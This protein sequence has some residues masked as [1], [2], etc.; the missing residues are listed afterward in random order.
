[1]KTI[2]FTGGGTGGHIYPGIAVAQELQNLI[3][4]RIL[5]IGNQ[6]GMDRSIVEA[7]GIEFYGIPS[8]KFRRYLSYKNLTDIGKVLNGFFKARSLLAQLKPTFLFS[9]GGFVS[10]P[11]CAAAASLGIPVFSHESDYTPG[12]A[13]KINSRFSSKLFTAYDDTIRF[14]P[15][16]VQSRSTAVGNPVRRSFREADADAGRRFLGIT[17]HDPV[18]LVLG[19]SQGAMQVNQ[20]VEESF[21]ELSE[22]Y[23]IVHQTGPAHTSSLPPS[24]RYKVFPYIKDE[25]P[26]VLAASDVVLGRSG[27]GTVW[28]A[29]IAG[30]PMVLIPLSGSGSRGDQVVN[31]RYFERHGAAVVLLGPDANKDRLVSELLDLADHAERRS[32]MAEA[33]R[34]IGSVDAAGMLAREIVQFIKGDPS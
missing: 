5:W 4:C 15:E 3:P 7:A 25:M 10:V 28:E 11:P 17:S 14:L 22:R 31:A 19:G 1:M 9:K 8:G 20:L 24:D 26:H 23:I 32:A 6:D 33:A 18:L 34:Q 12:L 13:T 30:K 29:A 16:P 27:A 2:V 21:R